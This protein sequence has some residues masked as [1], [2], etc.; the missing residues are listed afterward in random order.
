MFFV[1]Y[2]ALSFQRKLSFLLSQAL[3][4]LNVFFLCRAQESPMGLSFFGIV[5]LARVAR[6]TLGYDPTL[7]F[8]QLYYNTRLS[9]CLA[10]FD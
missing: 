4:P 8:S 10:I 2:S 6:K 5:T 3:N 1:L 7:I 9:V